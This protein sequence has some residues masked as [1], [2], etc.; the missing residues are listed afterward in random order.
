[1]SD[2]TEQ[3][4]VLGTNEDELRRLGLQHSVW[5][6]AALTCWQQAGI[7]VGS[8]VL[9]IGAGPRYA[10]VDLAELV[11]ATGEV[12][13]VERSARFVQAGKAACQARGLGNVRFYELDLMTDP[14][15]VSGFD[16]AWIRW[17]ACFI[18]S[19]ATLLGKLAQSIRPGGMLIFH[20]YA[21]YST[22]RV[23]P[24]SKLIEEFVEHVMESWRAA[25]GEPDIALALPSMMAE[26]GFRI[27]AATPRVFCIRPCDH[28]W[29]W[30][31][32]FIDNNLNRLMEL[33][34]VDQSWVTAVR[35]E[36]AAIESDPHSLM[37]TPMVLELVAE[38]H[39]NRG[40]DRAAMAI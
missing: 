26:H 10:T 36:F 4:Y 11:G 22:W 33:K 5:R 18:S 27:R 34:R 25:S 3:D 1:M 13:A 12:A 2:Q 19:P 38:L 7:T 39:P 32:A 14:L 24:R 31:A 8:R 28:V 17:V 20:E 37:L 35:R 30:P 15:P 21:D 9:D 29:R 16:A 40:E 6:P 23:A